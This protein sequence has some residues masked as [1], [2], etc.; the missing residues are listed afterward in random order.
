M[1]LNR[2]VIEVL[3]AFFMF[4]FFGFFY[5]CIGFCHRTESDLFL[6]L[7]FYFRCVSYLDKGQETENL[8]KMFDFYLS[9]NRRIEFYIFAFHSVMKDRR[10]TFFERSFADNEIYTFSHCHSY[11]YGKQKKWNLIHKRDQVPGEN[12]LFLWH[13]TSVDTFTEK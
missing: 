9:I 8:G 1:I 10:S 7:F 11:R 13:A 2:C 3:V 5:D 12:E 6:F 4:W